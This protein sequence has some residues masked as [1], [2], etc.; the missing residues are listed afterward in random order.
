MT[1]LLLLPVVTLNHGKKIAT[2]TRGDTAPGWRGVPPLERVRGTNVPRVRGWHNLRT[3]RGDDSSP[4]GTT[5]RVVAYPNGECFVS[6][7][8]PEDLVLLLWSFLGT[9]QFLGVFPGFRPRGQGSLLSGEG[10]PVAG[11]MTQTA[12]PRGSY[13]LVGG[14]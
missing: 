7:A 9:S 2:D 14:F 8:L 4:S 3:L 1:V 6:Y 10:A 11:L 12:C 13:P 5:F